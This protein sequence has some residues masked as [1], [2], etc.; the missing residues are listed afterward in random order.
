MTHLFSPLTIT[1]HD[2][3]TTNENLS[4]TFGLSDDY[5]LTSPTR[6]TN[7]SDANII[8][9]LSVKRASTDSIIPNATILTNPATRSMS[10]AKEM[11][12]ISAITPVNDRVRGN[13]GIHHNPFMFDGFL[14]DGGSAHHEMEVS[15]S[16]NTRGD[17]RRKR[18]SSGSSSSASL[19]SYISAGSSDQESDNDSVPEPKRSRSG[20]TISTSLTSSPVSSSC[21]NEHSQGS[22][23][24]VL[25]ML[26]QLNHSSG[27]SITSAENSP[28]LSTSTSPFEL[29]ADLTASSSVTKKSKSHSRR[30]K[31]EQKL[32]R[33]EASIA[34]LTASLNATREAEYQATQWAQQMA[35]QAQIAQQFALQQQ[36][37]A[38]IN[39]PTNY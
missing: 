22:F 19:S 4:D 29:K 20:L 1:I 11:N 37:E 2:D 35:Q 24:P 18:K 38:S 7:Q 30:S 33:L 5:F 9:S 14:L 32:Q 36:Q 12:Y 3:A 28:V 25:D 6:I 8:T 23:S 34:R 27:Q 15:T 21:M 39:Y 26:Q 10:P 13:S 17:A 31:S 16:N